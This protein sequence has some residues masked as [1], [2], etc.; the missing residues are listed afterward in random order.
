VINQQRDRIV[1]AFDRELDNLPFPAEL[2]SQ[3]VRGAVGNRNEAWHP[4]QQWPLALVAAFLAV[5]VVAT[6]VVGTRALRQAPAHVGPPPS[7]RAYAS[8]A[9]DEAHG[10]LVLFGGTVD[11]RV[12]L[13]ETWTW[14]G[15]AWTQ[16]HP[17]ISPPAR[18]MASMA[19][20]GARHRVVLLGGM[21]NA[22][23][24]KGRL[25]D[26]WTWDGKTW[27][28]MHPANQP[29]ALAMPLA[30]DPT[31]HMVIGLYIQPDQTGTP[32]TYGWNG[33]DWQ[34]LHPTTQ[35]PMGTIGSLVSDGNRLLLISQPFGP[36][37]GRYFSQ[38]WS[39]DGRDWHRLNPRFNLPSAVDTVFDQANGQVVALNGETWTWEG[40]TWTRQ[41]P[42]TTPTGA[43]YIAYFP[44]LRKVLAWGDRYSGQSG[45]LWAWDGS[46]WTLVK[47]GPPV[48]PQPGK[49]S[50]AQGPMSPA[51]AE[52]V[53]RKTVDSVRPVLIPGWLPAGLEAQVTAHSGGYDVAYESDQREKRVY[54][55][56]VVANPPIGT[57]KSVTRN[58]TFR[59]VTASYRIIDGTAALSQRSLMWNEPGTMPDSPIKAPG[60]PYFLSTDG[61]TD[62]EFWQIAN[63]LR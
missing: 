17:A 48:P 45:D 60:I 24:D 15:T 13:N 28:Q 46:N 39:W 40:S 37:G 38:T 52:A 5:A 16:M 2:R 25:T 30:Y 27:T 32:H 47:A 7:P 1:A 57:D 53:I 3:A 55:G 59:G 56:I 33:S 50:L 29:T 21:S 10:E 6:V 36:E 22:A 41:H 63:S 44:T 61:L 18:Q 20:D 43:P 62:Q 8:V 49:G 34:E 9:F 14:D 54:F 11:G 23:P 51:D 58:V 19:Y 42:T 4:R 26:T 35:P 12:M 31:S